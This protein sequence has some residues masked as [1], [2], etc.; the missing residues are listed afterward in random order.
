MGRQTRHHGA[1]T[2]RMVQIKAGIPV[3][4]DLQERLNAQCK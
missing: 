4:D 2:R 1:R 3:D